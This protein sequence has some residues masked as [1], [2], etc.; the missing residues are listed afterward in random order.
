M[1]TRKP[2]C[3]HRYENGD[4]CLDTAKWQNQWGFNLCDEHLVARSTLDGWRRIP[5][6]PDLASECRAL[7]AVLSDLLGR[8]D[9]VVC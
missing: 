6:P 1:L 7:R 9:E 5:D 4:S 3:D 2:T 8:G